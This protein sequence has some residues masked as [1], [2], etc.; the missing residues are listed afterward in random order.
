MRK[1]IQFTFLTLTVCNVFAQSSTI[2]ISKEVLKDKI[3]G[4]WAGQTIGVTFGG[5]YEFKFNGT[6][7]QQYQPLVWYDGYVKK[8]MLET[9]GLYDDLYICLLYTSPSPRDRQKSRMPS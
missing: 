1:F 9:P 2:K 4:G 8:T 6:F 3:K 5:P 7:I